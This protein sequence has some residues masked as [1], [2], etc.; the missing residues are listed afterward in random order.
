VGYDC[1]TRPRAKCDD[2]RTWREEN[3]NAYFRRNLSGGSY[4]AEALIAAGMGFDAEQYV[5]VPRFPDADEY[6][7]NYAEWKDEDGHWHAGYVGD[8]AGEYNAEVARVLA[9]HGPEIPGIPVHKVCGSNDGWH[10]TK[11]EC[12]AALGLYERHIAKGGQHPEAFG[13]DFIPFLRESARGDGFEV[14]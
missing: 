12:K 11:E 3:P 8:R 9:W 6:G 4:L 14:H 5:S 13:D 1:Y 2:Y 7:V 10:V